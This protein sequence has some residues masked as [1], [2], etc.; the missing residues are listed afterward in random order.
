[1]K[2]LR[3]RAWYN[4]E[5][6]FENDCYYQTFRRKCEK[7]WETRSNST[8]KFILRVLFISSKKICGMFSTHDDYFNEA[9]WRSNN[10]QGRW[11]KNKFEVWDDSLCATQSPQL[12]SWLLQLLLLWIQLWL[13]KYLVASH[14]FL[15][16]A[17][18]PGFLK[19]RAIQ[20]INIYT[21]AH[22]ERN[23]TRKAP[24]VDK[25]RKT[26]NKYFTTC[27]L[28]HAVAY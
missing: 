3:P 7:N 8:K 19:A 28:M 11:K 16:N 12:F 17:A 24:N 26:L 6:S 20:S 2:F 25:K 13:L 18:A 14:F 22:V 15:L 9:C 1:M 23:K 21:D 10:F 5:L 27:R 4:P